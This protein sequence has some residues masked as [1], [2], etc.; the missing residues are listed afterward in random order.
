MFN[1]ALILTTVLCAMLS[2]AHADEFGDFLD[3]IDEEPIYKEIDFWVGSIHLSKFQEIVEKV[4]EKYPKYLKSKSWFEVHRLSTIQSEKELYIR[5]V[6]QYEYKNIETMHGSP[7][8]QFIVW[9]NS[10]KEID[11]V[12][13]GNSLW[14]M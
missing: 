11:S 2:C 1:V 8:Q 13:A 3:K 4:R 9:V 10:K 14:P 7:K 12:Y 6:M 5:I